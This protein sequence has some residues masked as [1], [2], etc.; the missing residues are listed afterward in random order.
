VQL[1]DFP[2]SAIAPAFSP[3][4]RMLTFM[5]GGQG[6]FMR[7][8]QIYVK[9]FP[10]G[11]AVQLTDISGVRY[12]PVFSPDNSRVAYTEF[13]SKGETSPFNTWTV[14]VHGGSPS[15]LLPNAA[16][17]SW[18]DERH[19]LY[20]EIK[21][22]G[23]HMG[24]VT[25]TEGRADEREIYFP[26]HERGMAHYSIPSP[27][28]K[29]MLVPEM[30]GTGNFRS[31]RVVPFDGNS[32][33]RE[34]GPPGICLSAAWS[35]D[36]A[37][38][39]FSVFVQ[40]TSHLWRQRF[41]GGSPEQITFGPTEE[42]GVAVAPDGSLV[43]SVGQRQSSVWI[44]DASGQERPLSSEGLAYGP[45]L[46]SDGKRV[47]Y[48]LRQSPATDFA[49]LRVID[50][51][52]GRNDRPVPDVSVRDFD[53]SRDE[54]EV[55]YTTKTGDGKSEIWLAPL[56]HSQPAHRITSDGD[57]VSFGAGDELIF[58]G[59][60][61]T[62]NFLMRVRKDGT[63]HERV[64]DAPILE[65]VAVSPD[66][67]WALGGTSDA[68]GSG[69]PGLVAIPLRGG[70]MRLICR[71]Y[72]TGAWSPDGRFLY[73]DT[74]S[75]S[76]PGRTLAFPIASGESMPE[77]PAGVFADQEKAAEIPGVKL[78]RRTSIAPSLS[79]E[80]FVFVRSDFVGNLFQI[81]LH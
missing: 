57:N 70:Q 63:G 46:S 74:Q 78:I 79:P 50:L 12:G 1:T 71:A 52:T 18:I 44:H 40:G 24:I 56:D 35:P 47:Y 62:Q 33:G 48:L 53:I 60:D 4:G 13:N 54:R 45:R 34:V 37:W 14:P 69:L 66:G 67:T 38:M 80:T 7:N 15:L 26:D 77:L 58:R 76:D 23:A 11:E 10:K 65:K 72:C 36:G 61:K 17:L 55:A 75:V 59:F 16:G 30:D 5:R 25:A 21:G 39:Y 20:S 9:G 51:E 6:F 49:E 64:S 19:V 81:P 3:D 27:D 31:C 41:D 68:A 29:W 8:A 2:D 32:P 22:T 42:T 43:S 73:V 28:H